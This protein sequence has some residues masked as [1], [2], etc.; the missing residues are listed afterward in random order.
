MLAQPTL[1][2][3]ASRSPLLLLSL[4]LLPVIQTGRATAAEQGATPTSASAATQV[5]DLGTRRQGHDWP[6]FLG[7]TGDSKSSQRAAF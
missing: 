4:C 7:P 6:A 3:F 1:R 2:S 5:P